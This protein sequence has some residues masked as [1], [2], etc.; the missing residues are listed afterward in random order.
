MKQ[1][2]SETSKLALKAR[3]E[4]YANK[5][6]VVF[7]RSNAYKLFFTQNASFFMDLSSDFKTAFQKKFD[8]MDDKTSMEIIVINSLMK[9]MLTP[10]PKLLEFVFTNVYGKAKEEAEPKTYNLP[11]MTDATDILDE[12]DSAS[13]KLMLNRI[14][15]KLEKSVEV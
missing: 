2:N 4:M 8:G 7:N 6:E 1:F 10:D 11:Q 9:L 14:Q 13:L 5:Q 15:K 3:A 12:L